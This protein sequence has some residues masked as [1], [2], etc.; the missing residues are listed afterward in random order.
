MSPALLAQFSNIGIIIFILI[1]LYASTF[2]DGGS[3]VY[4]D[5]K[6]WDWVNNYWCDLIWPTTITGE[7]N[8]SSKWGIIANALLCFSM[9]FF[10][11]AFSMVYT[12]QNSWFY[13]ISISGT[14]SMVCSMFI[15]SSL[16]DKIIGVIVLTALPAIVGVIYGLI[17]FD[18]QIALYWGG[19]AL[20]SIFINVY[21]F[22]TKK[23]KKIL[24]LIQKF[25]FVI[26][27]G[28]VYFINTT[29]SG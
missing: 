27:L 5:K 14:I 3:K 13:I 10:F 2:Y 17:L 9:I 29:M 24:P 12:S 19:A 8:R 21:I 4:P 28:W 1:F 25:A 6:R 11:I 23:G 16:H 26:V 18:Q 15:F 22:Y 7:P 20:F